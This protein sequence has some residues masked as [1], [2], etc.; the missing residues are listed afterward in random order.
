[1][2]S[3]LRWL[4]LPALLLP[5]SG[6]AL[7]DRWFGPKEGPPL[8]GERIAVLGANRAVAADPGLAG[9][10][11]ALPPPSVNA[12]WPQ[13]GGTAE[14]FVGHVALPESLQR[15]WSTN[16]GRGSDRGSRL[17]S[18]PVVA[19]G[20]VY[21]MDG[22]ARVTAV[23]AGTGDRIWSVDLT[24]KGADGGFG[25]GLAFADGRLYATTGYGQ[26]VALD[27]ASGDEYWRRDVRTPLRSA[28]T[29]AGGRVY[30]ITLDNRTEAVD[31]ATGAP[32]WTHS[33]I[34]E[35]ASLLGHASPAAGEGIVVVPYSSGEIFGLRAD[36]G[37]M[38][39]S[40]GL[41]SARRSDV[42]S[43][44]SDIR[45]LPVLF[46]GAAIAVSHSGRA[47]AI[48]LH[49]GARLWDRDYGGTHTPAVAGDSF[50]LL[51]TDNQLLA[52][53]TADGR[54]RWTADLP[55]YR[56]PESRS[57]RIVWAGP[58]LAGGRLILTNSLGEA[59]FFSP[60]NGEQLGSIRLPAATLLPP[61]VAGRTLYVLS[62]DATLSAYR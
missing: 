5:L 28:P 22:R 47:A 39:W 41:A 52:A 6:C 9:E 62:D 38:V 33:G 57:E 4:I 50:F 20:R 17:L 19:A 42:I 59:V 8:P 27:A 46:R 49:S 35:V 18:T 23:D 55:V 31:A 53:Q 2:R 51:T 61:V 44:L 16:I 10:P 56:D 32:A 13:A 37:R 34:T 11:F 24:P 36:S 21:A 54:V 58:L 48:D 29:V 7:Y 3:R 1:M 30:A 40:D 15:A 12:E 25:G 43:D 14:H 45:G 60:Y 26:I